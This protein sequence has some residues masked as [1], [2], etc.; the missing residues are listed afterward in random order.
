[1]VVHLEANGLEARFVYGDQA[2]GPSP[3]CC[4]VELTQWKKTT[5]TIL[6]VEL[7]S[8]RDWMHDMQV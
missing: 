4:L 3:R 5:K 1:M 2:R 6:G 7:A 8:D